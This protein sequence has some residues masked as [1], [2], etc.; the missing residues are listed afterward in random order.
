MT[1]TIDGAHPSDVICRIIDS[2]IPVIVS[3]LNDQIWKERNDI[4]V[5]GNII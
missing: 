4:I 1:L 5:E 2:F 3:D